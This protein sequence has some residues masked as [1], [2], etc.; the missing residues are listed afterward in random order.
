MFFSAHESSFENTAENVLLKLRTLVTPI[1]ETILTS[2]FFLKK[3]SAKTCIGK[4]E[5]KF[6][7]FAKI[8]LV[9]VQIVLL[10]LREKNL[11]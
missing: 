7:F 1:Q 10:E 6:H 3:F 4:L 2:I 11:E 5:G 9:R 8:S